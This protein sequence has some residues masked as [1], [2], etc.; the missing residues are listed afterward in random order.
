[1]IVTGQQGSNHSLKRTTEV[2]SSH[3]PLASQ[4]KLCWK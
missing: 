1:M 2:S 4:T 3:C